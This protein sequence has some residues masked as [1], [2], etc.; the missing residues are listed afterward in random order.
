MGDLI[1]RETLF[2]A[3]LLA[4][5][6]VVFFLFY[7]I[8]A[9]FLVPIAWAA[10][11]VVSVQPAHKWLGRRVRRPWLCALISTVAV[12]LLILLPCGYLTFA[13]VG[14]AIGMYGRMQTWWGSE[15]ALKL[16]A[17]LDPVV[18]TLS[19]RFKGVVDL[20]HWNFRDAVMG[21]VG[22]F[23]AFIVGF[24]S[25]ALANI[26]RVGFQFGVMLISMYYL[27][28]DGPALVGHIETS[29][30]LPA[31]RAAH[32]LAH[33][34]AVVRATIYGGLAVAGIQGICG[35]LLFWILGLHSAV[36]WG[37]VMGFLSLVPLLGAFI[38]Y[39]PAAIVLFIAG[40]YIKAAILVLVGIGLVSQID[41]FIKPML[42]SSRT[43]LHPLLIF[44]AIGGGVSVFGFLGLVLGPVIAA[45]FVAMFD[46]Y[47]NALRETG[48]TPASP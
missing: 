17:R 2:G 11:L 13:L 29:I 27:F 8:I 43:Q 23:G 9:P 32:M 36:F 5:I 24:G 15:A 42:M 20:T 26:A 45:V 16:A 19:D 37:T 30:P 31:S 39:I 28:K 35:G 22:K 48:D 21:A 47:R 38:V 12:A 3:A 10:I 18:S 6:A 41:N 25:T 44:F 14:E 40:S 33:I 1:K 4:L 46:L 34:T 7:R